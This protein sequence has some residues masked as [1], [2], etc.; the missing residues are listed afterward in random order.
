DEAGLAFVDPDATTMVAPLHPAALMAGGAVEIRIS[1]EA[2]SCAPFTFTVDAL[3]PAPGEFATV[4]ELWQDLLDAQAAMAGVTVSD[5]KTR[6]MEDF[7]LPVWGLHVAQG[8]LDHPATANSLRALAGGTAP[9][10]QEVDLEY[11]EALIA[12]MG[13]RGALERRIAAASEG[14]ALL[15]PPAGAP[16]A[17]EIRSAIDCLSGIEDEVALET[18][19]T[20]ARRNILG[21]IEEAYVN[22]LKNSLTFIQTL[23]ITH[24]GFKQLFQA[25]SGL[26]LLETHFADYLAGV[27]PTEF[28]SMEVQPN[29]VFF[30][31]DTPGPGRWTPAEVRAVS[32]GWESDKLLQEI[33]LRALKASDSYGN[34]VKESGKAA[35]ARIGLEATE[36]AWN[37]FLANVINQVYS[38]I[39]K[40]VFGLS[41]E[42]P[43]VPPETFGP[44]PLRSE[45]YVTSRMV[46]DEFVVRAGHDA[47]DPRKPGTDYLHVITAA[48]RF[49]GVNIQTDP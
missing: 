35:A 32:K 25:L 37:T 42:G 38:A 34:F 22:D 41:V 45:A 18:C 47:L 20:L 44:I 49:G 28:V 12:S 4:V 36:T 40:G 29:P 1:D 15:N 8:L 14:V 30:Y 48:G 17:V 27:L 23:P 2:G 7:P 26:V 10:L 13:M 3:T 43:D 31:E 16:A 39:L 19:M 6:P 24:Q 21:P 5:L 11:L 9:D 46:L 33:M